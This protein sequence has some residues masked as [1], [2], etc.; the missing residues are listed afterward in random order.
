M[1]VYS[2]IIALWILWI[3][4]AIKIQQLIDKLF[5]FERD[6]AKKISEFNAINLT[7]ADDI[8]EIRKDINILHKRTIRRKN[9][10]RTHIHK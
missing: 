10:D 1:I 3:I 8:E 6:V 4:S 9:N 2:L 5:K 7:V